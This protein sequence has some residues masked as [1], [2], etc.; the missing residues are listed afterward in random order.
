MERL[1]V[2]VRAADPLRRTA[3]GRVVAEAGHTVVGTHDAADVVLV[4]GDC[5]SGETRPVVT[6]GGA[7]DDLPGVLPGDANASQIDAAYT[8]GRRRLDRPYAR[9]EGRWLRRDARD[10]WPRPSDAA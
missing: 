10:R 7:D 5:P 9:R 2:A 1:R 3:L 8:S 6:L 4:V